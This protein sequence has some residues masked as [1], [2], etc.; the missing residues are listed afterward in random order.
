MSWSPRDYSHQQQDGQPS[1]APPVVF[2]DS[3]PLPTYAEGLEAYAIDET[4]GLPSW[5]RRDLRT[6]GFCTER[7][8]ERFRSLMTRGIAAS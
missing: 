4:A 7:E 3:E 1:E 6:A 8:L 5:Q 2:Q